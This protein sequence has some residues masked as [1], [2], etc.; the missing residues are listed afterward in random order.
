[1]HGAKIKTVSVQQAK[2]SNYYKNTRLKLLK[3]NATCNFSKEQR[4]LPEDD[5][6]ME[7]CRSVLS[8][9]M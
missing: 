6:V 3:T 9:L 1:M 2:L 4:M 5:R 8:A 7:T